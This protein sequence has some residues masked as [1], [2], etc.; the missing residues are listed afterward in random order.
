VSEAQSGGQRR[1]DRVLAPDF[2]G[3]LRALP[4]EVLR[5]RRREA[6]QE[7]VDLSYL[8]RLLQGRLDI[9]AAEV[10][11]RRGGT[12]GRSVLAHLTDILAEGSA[13]GG[14]TGGRRHQ[15]LEPT[16]AERQRRRVEALVADAELSDVASRSDAQLAHWAELLEAEEQRT[17]D[18]RAAVQQVMD[19]CGAEIGRRYRDGEASVGDLLP[20]ERS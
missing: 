14:S 15:A 18:D 13:G 5:E 2:L 6:E 17:S 10:S 12:D 11:R 8:R 7:E 19:R 3:E 9:I 16:R 20:G 4:M 1:L